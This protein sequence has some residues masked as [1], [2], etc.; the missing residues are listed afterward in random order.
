MHTRTAFLLAAAL[1]AALIASGCSSSSQAAAPSPEVVALQS[2]VAALTGRVTTLEGQFAGVDASLQTLEALPG[3][4]VEIQA[5]LAAVRASI[6]DTVRLRAPTGQRKARFGSFAAAAEQGQEVGT[7][8]QLLPADKPAYASTGA[9]LSSTTGFLFSVSHAAVPV[10][11]D[12]VTPLYYASTDCTGQGYVGFDDISFLGA[13]KGTAF[14]LPAADPSDPQ[15][16]YQV[17]AGSPQVPVAFGSRR[18]DDTTCEVVSSS[19]VGYAVQSN[20]PEVSG[21]PSGKFPE[22]LDVGPT[23]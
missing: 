10:A 4:T 13:S 21:V 23:G 7:V 19:T 22:V 14:R 3:T 12:P 8:L 2:S 11:I 15:W 1:G 20:D 9:S 6:R 5:E 17:P 16:Y 18:H